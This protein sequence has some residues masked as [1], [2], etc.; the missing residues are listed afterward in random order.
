M[1]AALK[2]L[3][4]LSKGCGNSVVSISRSLRTR[5]IRVRSKAFMCESGFFNTHAQVGRAEAPAPAA[6]PSKRGH[7]VHFAEAKCICMEPSSMHTHTVRY[8]H[9]I[10]NSSTTT[11]REK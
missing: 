3:A 2:P 11:R 9:E 1:L 6:L 7:A 10:W 5:E 4:G 8:E